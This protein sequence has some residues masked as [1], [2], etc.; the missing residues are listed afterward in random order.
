MARDMTKYNFNG[1]ENLSK[2][3]T[4]Y[5][6]IKKYIENSPDVTIEDLKKVFN[7]LHR[8]FEVCLSQSEYSEYIERTQTGKS[9]YFKEPIKLLDD[10]VYICNQWGVF[11]KNILQKASE[12]GFSIIPV[13]VE[14]VA[15]ADNDESDLY[16]SSPKNII[17]YGPPGVGKTYSHKK[18]ISILE[19]E[20]SL[21]ELSNPDYKTIAFDSVKEEGR[22]QF[23]TFHQSY[24]YEDFI[25][26]FRPNKDGKITSESGI[27]KTF[28]EDVDNNYGLK[29]S[30]FFEKI[31][32]D[33]ELD[34]FYKVVGASKIV[35]LDE[36][37]IVI[38]ITGNQTLVDLEI[39]KLKEVWSYYTRYY[40]KNQ[41]T[42]LKNKHKIFDQFKD[43]LEMKKVDLN[44]YL[45]ILRNFIQYLDNENNNEVKNFYFIIDEINRGNISKIFG[46]LITLLEEDKRLGEPN[47]LTV[48]LPY[49]KDLFG[50]PAN[51]YIIGTMNTADKSIALV[52][53]ALR[54]RFT[55]VRM[56]PIDNYL[57]D[58]VKK[59]NGIIKDR[60]GP[61]YLIGH[62]YFIDKD[63][64][65]I[66]EANPK[67]R[68]VMDYKIR[69]LLEEYFYGED[70]D[71]I[72]EGL[73]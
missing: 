18:L 22:Y 70:I 11:F 42:I 39:S 24:S 14:T 17:L 49:S 54:R 58:N 27:F 16:I 72:F 34:N 2:R 69:P 60:R 13:T 5:E 50:V 6:L 65:K 52:D 46:E 68:F 57:S 47:E 71:G 23:L 48:T 55:F 73:L 66:D 8:G 36:T 19:N 40:K 56:D 12:I 21:E 33:I 20:D 51:L 43:Y 44:D 59:I 1:L 32:K 4:V 35:F 3:Q 64:S 63:G 26:G 29:F 7:S 31:K 62:A 10:Q 53:I 67:Y 25:E 41:K 61:D 15:G 30:M 9:R 28:I 37:K 38:D 45:L